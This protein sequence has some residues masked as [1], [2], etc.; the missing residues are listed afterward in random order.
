[1]K[2]RRYFPSLGMLREYKRSVGKDLDPFAFRW[3]K[4]RF[5]SSILGEMRHMH[6]G[7]GRD[8]R[9]FKSEF[10]ST[11]LL[12]VLFWLFGLE[13]QRPCTVSRN[14]G[15]MHSGGTRYVG[16]EEALQERLARHRRSRT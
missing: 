12:A 2:R 13:D 9:G 1:M 8:S 3:E 16:G 10:A 5:T 15:W 6:I 7:R 11:D 14:C 4:M